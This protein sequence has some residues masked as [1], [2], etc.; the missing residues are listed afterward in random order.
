[1]V[2]TRDTYI[3]I[4]AVGPVMMKND[5]VNAITVYVIALRLSFDLVLE[6]LLMTVMISIVFIIASKING[7]IEYK[8]V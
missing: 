5:K 3:P 7:T 6:P 4:M 2:S 8:Y 1:M